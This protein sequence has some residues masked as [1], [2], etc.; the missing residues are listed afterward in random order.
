ME[1]IR[2]AK[3]MTRLQALV[4]IVLAL[5]LTLLSGVGATLGGY[6][7]LG[8]V[9]APLLVVLAMQG[10]LILAGLYGLLRRRGQ[11]WR[12][13]GLGPLRGQD[14][15]RT[16]TALVLVFAA[17][18]LLSLLLSQLSP[19]LVEGHQERLADLAGA[20]TGGL[21]VLSVGGVMLFVGFYEEILARGFLLSR[22]S[23]LLGG[24]WPPVL[25]SSLLFGLGHAYQGWT[26]V[27]QTA[28][29]GVV[30]ARLAL[31]WGTLWPLILAHAALN[32]IS[33]IVLR[34]LA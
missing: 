12:D 17:S 8:E 2:K 10:L 34:G 23:S 33:L 19:G 4:D 14:V 32:T 29:V 6:L 20:L 7:L 15:G 16:L 5:V 11:R 22:A 13:L 1:Q 9:G 25:V 27:V 31:R 28:V 26:G 18:S 24:T 21:S 30:L 3:R